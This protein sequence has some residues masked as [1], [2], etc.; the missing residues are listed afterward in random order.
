[1]SQTGVFKG[2]NE[3]I[4]VHTFLAEVIK[5]FPNQGLFIAV[6]LQF[7]CFRINLQE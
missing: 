3:G 6:L 5:Q 4:P 1:M 2:V 7:C